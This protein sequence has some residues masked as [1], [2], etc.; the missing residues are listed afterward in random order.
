[1]PDRS[2]AHEAFELARRTLD[3]FASDPENARRVD[4][5]ARALAERLTMGGKLLACGNGGSAAQASHLCEE[6]TGRF[7]DDR[8]PIAAM[9]CNDAGHI[10]C[11]A[12]DYGFGAIFERWITAL[13]GP[14]D[15]VVLLSTSGN[16][17]NIV[18]AARAARQRGAM[19]VGLLGRGGGEAAPLC[20]EWWD[21][22]GETADR[23]QEVHTV[24]IHA[25]IEGIEGSLRA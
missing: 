3:A 21:V 20:D 2:L 10:T 16:S 22:H 7:R 9:A 23:V 1:M 12:N 8:P 24:I 5:V 6:L 14:G 11:T 13:A 18:R 19:V 17:E 15:A 25:L 4:R